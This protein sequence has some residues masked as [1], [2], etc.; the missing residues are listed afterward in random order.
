MAVTI[1][2]DSNGDLFKYWFGQI[3]GTGGTGGVTASLYP[4]AYPFG[5]VS[6]TACGAVT[7]AGNTTSVVFVSTPIPAWGMAI[8]I[9]GNGAAT[10]ET[11]E[12]GGQN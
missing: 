7:A 1:G 5:P 6:P 9:S 3:V 12:G 11:A 2:A 10:T 8:S 4:I